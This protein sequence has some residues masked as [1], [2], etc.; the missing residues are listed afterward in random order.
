MDLIYVLTS[1][2]ILKVP[3]AIAL[4]LHGLPGLKEWRTRGSF[5]N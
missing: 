5:S 3:V 1:F 4:L 2:G